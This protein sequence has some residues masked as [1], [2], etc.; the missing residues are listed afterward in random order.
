MYKVLIIE[1][2]KGP[3]EDTGDVWIKVYGKRQHHP[4]SEEEYLGKYDMVL[5]DDGDK[6]IVITSDGKRT[7][8]IMDGKYRFVV[9]CKAFS[10]FI[11]VVK[12][13]GEGNGHK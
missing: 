3:F 8:I 7:K 2:T 9:D 1:P 12:D 10:L 6:A 11:K 13:R 4:K 5:I